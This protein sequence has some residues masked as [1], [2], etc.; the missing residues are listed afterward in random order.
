[1]S[2]STL[3]TRDDLSDKGASH[4]AETIRQ[5]KKLNN[6]K[7]EVLIPDFNET[8]LRK[9]IQAKP[10][11]IAHNIEVAKNE[12]GARSR[13][14]AEVYKRFMTEYLKEH[15]LE[16]G[17]DPTRVAVGTGYTPKSL[18]LDSVANTSGEKVFMTR[19]S[20]FPISFRRS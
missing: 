7:V 11:V 1:L 16:Q 8:E 20:S 15:A 9:V 18:V 5:I 19:S 6:C 14:I 3:Q 17:L 13:S 10:Y 12:E 2:G 4:F